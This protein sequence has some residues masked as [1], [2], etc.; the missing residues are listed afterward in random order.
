M[1]TLLCLGLG[2]VQ[3]LLTVPHFLPFGMVIYILCYYRLVVCDWFGF[4]FF[5]I[6][7]GFMV[8]RLPGVSEETL[9]LV[10]LNSVETE[11]LWGL[12]KLD[13]MRDTLCL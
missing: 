11:R 1:F 10:I 7:Q 12:L 13:I 3:C 5:L 6:L 9:D 8:R 2:L 4:L